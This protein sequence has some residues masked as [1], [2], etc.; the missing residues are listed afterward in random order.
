[1]RIVST[2]AMIRSLDGMLGTNNL[3][4]WE[5]GFVSSISESTLAGADTSRL[6]EKQLERLTELYRKHFA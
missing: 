2:N 3:S 4:D 1:M 6:T 5:N